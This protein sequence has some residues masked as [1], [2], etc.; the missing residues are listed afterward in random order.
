MID[1]L[2]EQIIQANESYRTGNPEISDSEYDVLVEKLTLFSPDDELLVQIG[3]VIADESR[4]SKLPIIMASMNK[5]KIVDELFDWCRLRR[6]RISE[7]VIITPKFD[8]VS[9]CVDEKGGDD[10]WTR[11]DGVHG[12]KSN[13]HYELIGNHAKDLPKGFEYTFGEVMISKNTFT[14]KFANDFAN[15]RNL[16]AGL[17]NTPDA[18]ESLKSCEY[19]KYGVSLSDG[20]RHEYK[21]KQQII[22]ILNSS[23][24]SQVKYHV[25]KISELSDD[26]LIDLFHK[27]N[28][29]YD[30]DGLIIEI[31]DFKIQ[32]ILGRE[33]SGNPVWARAY[34]HKSF[35]QTAE[36]EVIG[37]TWNISKQGLLK[38]IIHINPVKLDGVT[39]SNITGNN[40]RFI[41]DMGIGIGA[42][43]IVRR[44]GMV[45]PIVDEVTKTVDFVMPGVPNIDWNDNGIELITLTE[46][47]EQ[48]FKQVVSFFEILEAA[49]VSEGVLKQIWD[50]GYVTIKDIL[51]LSKEDLEKLDRFGKRKAT[52][53]F[54]S[55]QK[56]V[57]DVEL[58][59]LQHA[60][61][62][63]KNL[64]SKKLVLLDHFSEKPSVD[65]IMKID[66]FAETSTEAYLEGY[67]KF[68]DF[69]KDLP[70]TIKEKLEVV[71]T[72][73]VLEGSQFVFT[74]VRRKDL[75]AVIIENGGKI[76]G[77]VS[78]NTTHLI[79][80]D[81]GS[82]SSKVVKAES[83]GVAIMGVSDL[84]SLLNDI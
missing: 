79:C 21:T 26:F 57:K 62:L 63:F 78:K 67:D 27:F 40:A 70:I 45:I 38:P 58:C 5:V 83:L 49:N 65:Q 36:T 55:I 32:D 3:H 84:E 18:T 31:N 64:G 51:A 1:K 11:G 17:L 73:S 15:S 81:P 10:A 7:Y 52:I 33:N 4:K 16:V 42:K 24:E 68:Y 34:K 2:R 20:A 13:S 53:V 54:N 76:G 19:V 39:V 72:S 25:C 60:T 50:A 22:D 66:G 43:I 74:G 44:S 30:I 28:T 41:K 37:I 59:K 47:D 80:K 29:D 35:E 46:T 71:S 82:G 61:G 69:I 14:T 6:I 23:Q 77:S 56:S 8:G 9:L 12:Q 48:K 75:E